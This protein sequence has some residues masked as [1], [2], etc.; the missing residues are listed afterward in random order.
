MRRPRSL[1]PL[2]IDGLMAVGL[3]VLAVLTLVGY[4]GSSEVFL[5]EADAWT[6]LLI[7]LQTLP[8]TLRRRY[9]QA[10]MVTVLAAFVV[11]RFLDYPIT[12]APAGLILAFHAIGS[13][14][15]PRR[16]FVLGY[17]LAAFVAL[18]T[19]L[20]A[21]TLESVTVASVISTALLVSVPVALGREVYQRRRRFQALED[22]ARQAERERE[23]RAHQAVTEERARIAR[24]LH[25]V[26]A[27]QMAV[28]TL[29]AEGAR[30]LITDGDPRIA[31]ALDTIRQTGHDGLNEMRRM[32]GLLRT[33]DARGEPGLAPQPGLGDLDRLVHQM[34]ETGLQVHLEREGEE[35]PLPSGLDLNAF[36]IVQESLTNALKHGGA[37]ASAT[38]TVR[39]LDDCLDLEITDDGGRVIPDGSAPAEATGNGQGQG[40]LGMRERVAMLNGEL[41]FG[42]RPTGG[43]R[44]HATLPAPR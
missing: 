1:P 31:G 15:A 30:R 38:V 10:V 4:H 2:V 42:P 39:Y 19:L 40:L 11:D 32:V 22:R 14:L 33:G 43:F 34:R 28:M 24:E 37:R 7:A 8:L 26:V 23:E 6:Y 20:G 27:H 41:S 35:R 13:E 25:D 18:F 17:G 9:P 36:R 3:F 12:P 21:L 16:S 5:R 29:Q 44:V